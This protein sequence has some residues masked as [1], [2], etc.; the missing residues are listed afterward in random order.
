MTRENIKTL[1][2]LLVKSAEIFG[3]KAFLKEKKGKNVIE[4]SFSQLCD[5]S[6]RVSS[7]LAE[8]SQGRTI[9]A[10]LIGATSSAYLTAYFG[11]SCGGNVIVPLDAQM[12]EEDLCD[13]LRR[14]DAEVFFF[15]KKFAPMLGAV[16]A[17][18]P[19]VKVFVSLQE[20]DDEISL[21]QILE[22]YE[23][24]E[25]NRLAPDS[26]AA[27]LFTSGTTGLS[28]GVMLLHSNFIDNTMCQD[29][30]STPDDVLLS[31]LPI[32]HVYCFTCDILLSL[33]YGATVCVNDSM[34][35]IAQNLKFFQPTIIL[36]VPMI[37]ET[38]YR[39]IRSAVE[40]DPSLDI[41]AV[42]KAVFGGN[43][44]GIYSGGAYLNPKLAEAY[45]GFGI[46][47]A[48]GYGMTECSPRI[49]TA[50]LDDT[51]SGSIGT[52]VNGCE[53][54]IVD[55]E[56][57]AKSPSVMAGYYKN[58]E[59]TAEAL[60]EDSWLRTGDLG[61][62]DSTRHLYITGRKKNL[63]ILS[64]GE[65]VSPEELENKFS[66]LEWI[67]EILVYAE[68]GMITAELY[69]NQ[70]FVEKNGADKVEELFRSHV[71]EIN[72]TVST[73]KAIRRMRIRDVEFNKTTSK[74]IK[75]EQE[76]AGR[77]LD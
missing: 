23:P 34:M 7:F 33:R 64:N 76:V 11:T 16:R 54:K 50:H 15:D 62:V 72:K 28:K 14:S 2:D 36:L 71:Q 73:A 38:I 61:Y 51:N 10:G 46:P 41:N 12:K 56:I 60:T 35:H 68:D 59:A 5:R 66:G 22:S 17:N 75:R 70:E 37:A 26:L 25:W 49:S 31:V 20:L 67:A 74:K 8:K 9:H 55:G 47:I 1:Q 39:K 63:I 30:E 65:N 19:Q 18:C 44:R 53:V 77:I 40:S 69:P 52:I 21:A 48:Q 29:N 3:D 58:P 32:H 27:I 24:A 6:R 57:W 4:T 42:A 43:L 13:H 45:H